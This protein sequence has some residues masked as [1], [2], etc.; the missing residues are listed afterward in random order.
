MSEL[1]DVNALPLP[2]VWAHFVATGLPERLLALARD[3][4]LGVQ[5][6]P[7]TGLGAGL[8][9][10]SGDVTSDVSINPAWRARASVVMR[11]S[12]VVCGLATLPQL[13]PIFAPSCSAQVLQPDGTAVAAMTAVAMLDGPLDELLGLERTLLNLLGRLSGVAT[14][15]AE[16]VACVPRASVAKVYDTR[17]TTPG[18]RVFEKYAVRCGGGRC[19]R[20]GL[21]DAVLLKDNHLAGVEVTRL[22]EYVRVA[23]AAARSRGGVR[24]VQV[25][26]D[27]IEQLEALLTLAPGTIDII[28]LD[29]MDTG[30]LERAVELRNGLARSQSNATAAGGRVLPELEASG[31]VT[32][33]TIAAIAASGVERISIGGLTHSA[34]W[35]DV[36]LDVLSVDRQRSM[37]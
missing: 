25:E 24:F 4:D 34:V 23:A 29:N 22:A 1:V 17:K 30:L 33:Q 12:G 36:A 6:V 28:L 31:G 16:F 10:G 19:H 5:A 9:G 7:S 18:L 15:T 8:P 35:V 21:H 26:V 14:R 27:T 37:A 11:S 13:L 20:L 3:E 32:V 2:Q